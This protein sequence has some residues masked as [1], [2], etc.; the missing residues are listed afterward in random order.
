[1]NIKIDAKNYLFIYKVLALVILL[2]D[3]LYVPTITCETDRG[4]TYC[5]DSGWQL[6]FNLGKDQIDNFNLTIVSLNVE[7]YIIQLLACLVIIFGTH[8]IFFKK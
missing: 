5:D 7:V 2:I 3:I 6:F 4:E 8:T 1:M